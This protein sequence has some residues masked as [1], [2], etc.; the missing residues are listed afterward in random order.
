MPEFQDL[1]GQRFGDLLV[2]RR[3]PDYISPT[4]KKTV[5]WECLCENCGRKT[6]MLRNTLKAATSCGCIRGK[7]KD[8]T[9]QRFGRW[10]VLER[11]RRSEPHA[12]GS[13]YDWKCLCDCGTERLVDAKDLTSGAS[14]SCGCTIGEEALKRIDPTGKNDLQRYSG[15]T[16]SAIRPERKPNS[17]NQS[18]VLGVYWSEREQRWIAK[19]GLRGKS[20]TI[21]RFDDLEKAKLA[22]LAAEEE[23]YN[24]IIEEFD[25]KKD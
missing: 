5:R 13:W 23:I 2:L 12:N 8:L 11:V 14:R 22:R 24:P 10:T 25:S 3:A 15:T 16:V 1:T 19:I 21:G 17:N 9:G 18:G 20:I 6:V 4:G 7:Y